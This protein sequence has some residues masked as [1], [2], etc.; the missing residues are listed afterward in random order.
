MFEIYKRNLGPAVLNWDWWF[1]NLRRLMRRLNS[2]NAD[3]LKTADLTRDMF[4]VEY[5][6]NVQGGRYSF[7]GKQDLSYE[8]HKKDFSSN[9]EPGEFGGEYVSAGVRKFRVEMDT[10]RTGTFLVAYHITGYPTDG[11]PQRTSWGKYSTLHVDGRRVDAATDYVENRSFGGRAYSIAGG[12]K[13][14]K[15]EGVR[16]SGF[17]QIALIEGAHSVEVVMRDR[18]DTNLSR[19]EISIAEVH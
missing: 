9:V 6:V 1:T 12:V 10:T 7:V 13:V 15:T 5:F 17:A 19:I 8:I 4:A 3:S 11:T 14:A 16:L 18:N 2:V